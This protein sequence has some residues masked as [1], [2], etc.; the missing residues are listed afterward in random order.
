MQSPE[1]QELTASEP[2]SLQEEYDM[3]RSWREDE[4]SKIAKIDYNYKKI[5]ILENKINFFDFLIFNNIN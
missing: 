3:Q 2:L 5:S 4:K 1:L